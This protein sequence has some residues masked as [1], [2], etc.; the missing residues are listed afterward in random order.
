MET[1]GC[2]QQEFLGLNFSKGFRKHS[3]VVLLLAWGKQACWLAPSVTRGAAGAMGTT[4]T[5][6]LVFLVFQGKGSRCC[7]R[8]EYRALS[9]C[10]CWETGL[11]T[12]HAK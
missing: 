2:V 5:V 7:R 9:S 10:M 3:T 11:T 1:Q 4:Y 8:R 6:V 12:E